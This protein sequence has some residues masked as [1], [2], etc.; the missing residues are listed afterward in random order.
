MESHRAMAY[1]YYMTGNYNEALDEYRKAIDIHGKLADLWIPLGDC[2]QAVDDPQAAIDSYVK[3]STYDSTNPD[4]FTR[5]SRVYAGQGQYG[6]AEQYAE[7][8][9]NLDPLNPRNHG[10]LG[11]M[12]YHNRKYA[13]AIP[14]LEL[15]IAGGN[16]EGGTVVGLPLGPFPVSEY[17][18][19]YGLALAKVG[20]CS[21]AVPVFRLLEQQLPD[22]L[23][24]ISNVSE[25]LM[26][27]KMIT[28]T[29][30]PQE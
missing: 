13:E 3:A 2:Q 15:A 18:W 22:D 8:A 17:Y 21:E 20:R 14:E 7:L 27:C 29:P 19:T 30:Q 24:A 25:G 12:H 6:K 9:V 11:V 5:I 28:P 26:I 10:L 23:D 4:P 1:I 16:V